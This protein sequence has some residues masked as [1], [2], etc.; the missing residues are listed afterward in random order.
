MGWPGPQ[1]CAQ[2][3]PG[4]AVIGV[5]TGPRVHQRE[6]ALP[7]LAVEGLAWPWPSGLCPAEARPGS[8]RGWARG[9]RVHQRELHP[10]GTDCWESL[11][12]KSI[13]RAN[14]FVLLILLMREWECSR[15]AN[16]CHIVLTASELRNCVH[17]C[18]ASQLFCPALVSRSPRSMQTPPQSRAAS[19]LPPGAPDRQTSPLSVA[20]RTNNLPQI[21]HLIQTDDSCLFEFMHGGDN[22][23]TTA[24]SSMN[25]WA[26]YMVLAAGAR[27]DHADRLG[28]TALALLCQISPSLYD[29]RQAHFQRRV[30]LARMLAAGG[31]EEFGPPINDPTHDVVRRAALH[32]HE[33][34]I[35][36][37]MPKRIQSIGYWRVILGFVRPQRR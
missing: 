25:P 37:L 7:S 34:L 3:R 17:S 35:V 16:L 21:Q 6:P 28:R 33:D 23:V 20:I 29:D 5:G 8:D 4:L 15:R 18:S 24:A 26:L 32:Y 9:L 31:A 22:A 12:W 11:H 1:D 30:L 36:A 19:P 10:L 27:P 2:L 13:G 14:G